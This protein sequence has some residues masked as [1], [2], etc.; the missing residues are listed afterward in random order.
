MKR[1]FQNRYG[2]KIPFHLLLG[3]AYRGGGNMFFD[4]SPSDS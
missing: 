1:D 3:D 2:L 4:I